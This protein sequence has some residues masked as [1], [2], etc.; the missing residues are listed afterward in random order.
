MLVVFLHDDRETF[1]VAFY[2][3]I[4]KN[5]VADLGIIYVCYVQRTCGGMYYIAVAKTYAAYFFSAGF[6][7]DFQCFAPVVPDNAALYYC[8]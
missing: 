4:F 1:L 5:Y 2:S 3:Y 8:V 6:G 7:A